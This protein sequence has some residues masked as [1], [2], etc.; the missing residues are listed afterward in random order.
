VTLQIWILIVAVFAVVVLTRLGRHRYTRRQRVLT[1]AVVAVLIIK[2]VR[3]MPT[4]GND[5]ALEASCAALGALFGLGM[6]AATS[7]ERDHQQGQV[8]VRAGLAYLVLWTVMLGSRIVFAYSA[9]GW[10]RHDIGHYFATNRLSFGAITPAFVLMTVASLV[11]VAL[12]TGLRASA[13]RS[14]AASNFR[15]PAQAG[16]SL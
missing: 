9:S 4:T 15:P 13:A 11:V 7:V 6:L 3:G 1:L 14:T 16:H 12:G 8:W 2:Y 5:W 10:A